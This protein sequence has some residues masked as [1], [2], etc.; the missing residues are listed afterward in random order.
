[1][2]RRP[3]RSTR[4]DTL[5]PY[6]TLFRSSNALSP[7]WAGTPGWGSAYKLSGQAAIG[8]S[9]KFDKK[10]KKF[11]N[12]LPVTGAYLTG[13][14]VY[15]PRLDSTF[16]GG[17]GSC[18]LGDEST[19]VYS[20]NPALHAGTYAYGRYQNGKRTFG[21]GLPADGIDWAVVAAWATV[22]ERTE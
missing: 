10:G 6:P 11:A 9:Y 12:G 17:S 7:Q 22:C 5:F 21:I 18:R 20:E 15:D 3:P 19:Y 4:T 13:V 2:I 8:W 16:P 1:M 14:K